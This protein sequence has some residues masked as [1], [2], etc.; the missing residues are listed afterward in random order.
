MWLGLSWVRTSDLDRH[1]RVDLPS[2]AKLVSIFGWSLCGSAFVDY[3][4][5]GEEC[6]LAYHELLQAVLV[7]R[8]FRPRIFIPRIWVDS[9]TSR[10]GGIAHWAIPKELASFSRGSPSQCSTTTEFLAEASLG[11]PLARLRIAS[12]LESSPG[13][14][15]WSHMTLIQKRESGEVVETAS[16]MSGSIRLSRQAGWRFFAEDPAKKGTLPLSKPWITLYLAPT[17]IKFG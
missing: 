5:Q 4:P 13:I 3:G 16:T 9:E 10:L 8:G 12:E 6:I 2:G 1:L 11:W 14:P 17:R 7:L 15:F